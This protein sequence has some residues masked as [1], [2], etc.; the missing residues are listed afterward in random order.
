MTKI[1]KSSF[2]DLGAA[3]QEDAYFFVGKEQH[4]SEETGVLVTKARTSPTDIWKLDP[5]IKINCDTVEI[6]L[7]VGCVSA[8]NISWLAII[9]PAKD[10]MVYAKCKIQQ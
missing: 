10:G 9:C 4:V 1:L 7:P 3:G 2:Y 6:E 8:S 5:K